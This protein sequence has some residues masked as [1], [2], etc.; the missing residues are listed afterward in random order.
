MMQG[1]LAER[2]RILRARKGLTLTEASERIGITRHTL[3]SLERGGQDPHYP[4]LRKISEGYDVPVEELLGE[5]LP[6]G[7]ASPETGPKVV[8]GAAHIEVDAETFEILRALLA[9]QEISGAEAKE[10]L[11]RIRMLIL[12]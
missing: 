12:Q 3:R 2:L 8:K 10:R 11:D 5:P 4:T 9:D 6:L 1:S 7:E